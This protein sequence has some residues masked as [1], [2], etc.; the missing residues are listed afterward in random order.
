MVGRCIRSCKWY[1][2]W[3]NYFLYILFFFVHRP[4]VDR[5]NIIKSN[6]ITIYREI[7]HDMLISIVLASINGGRDDLESDMESI[8]KLMN[9]VEFRK[10]FSG[11]EEATEGLCL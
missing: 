7:K 8:D 3:S 1:L 2:N 10:T 11:G 6:F 5:R 9:V 4:D